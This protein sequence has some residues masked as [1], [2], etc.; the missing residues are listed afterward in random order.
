MAK[1]TPDYINWVLTLNATQAQ[2]EF[3]KLEKANKELQKRTNA[4][5]KAMAQLEAEGKK[6][7][8]EWDNLRKSVDQ[9][10]RAMA[11]NR[12]KM[13]EVAKR[14][15]LASMSVSQLRKR[16]KDLQREFNNTSKAAD[17]GRY[18]ELRR[19]IN[20]VQAALDKA[21][22]SA[23]GLQGGFFS[24]TKMKQTIIGFFIGVGLTIFA[25]I[26][27]AF[28]DAFNLVVDFEKANSRLASVLGTGRN[29][30]KDLTAAA[31]ELGATTS[32]T[33][34]EV[35]GLQIELAKLG[36]DKGQIIQMEAAVLKFAKAVDTDL[37]RA[38]AFAGAA[39]R[40]FGKDAADTESVLATFAVATTKT[41]LDFSKL[42]TSMSI[43]GPVAKAFGLSLEDTTAL[44]GQLANAGFDASSAATATRNIILNLCDANGDLAKALGA[45]VR[46]AAD[47]A[48]GLK[49]L[50]AEGIDLAKAL[51]LTDKRSVAAFSTFLASADSLGQLSDSITGVNRQFNSMA[52]TMGDNVAGAM[53]GLQ[54]A[55][56]E[57]V[58]K[59]SEGTNGPVK[60]LIN[61]LTSLVR[62]IGNVYE[63]LARFSGIVKIAAVALGL[64]KAA[65][66]AANAATKL[67]LATMRSGSA[68]LGAFRVASL[69][70]SAAMKLLSG[71]LAGASVALRAFRI[72]LVST[73]I[74]ALVAVLG[75]LC[76]ALMSF[77]SNAGKAKEKTDAWA[78][79]MAEAGKRYGEQ[80]GKLVSLIMVAE[81]ENL[82]LAKRQKAIAQLNKI[83]PD[84]NAKI[85]ETTGK[86]VAAK[87]K[88]DLYLDSLEKEMRYKA[89]EDKLKELLGISEAARDA[90]D[91]AEIK[92]AEAARF[93]KGLDGGKEYADK[94]KKEARKLKKEWDRAE[95]DYKAFKGRMEKA[96]E[97][98]IIT[99]PAADPA[100]DAV[101]NTGEAADKLLTRLKEIN[102]ELGQLRKTDPQSDVQLQG[103]KDRIN[104]LQEEKKQILDNKKLLSEPGV[105]QEE[106]VMQATAQADDDHQLRQLEIN[107][108]RP[109]IPDSEYTLEKAR[110]T[111]RYCE[112]LK[113]A[114]ETLRA[115][116]DVTH[117]DTLAAIAKRENEVA[118]ELVT[119]RETVDKAVVRQRAKLHDDIM[120]SYQAAADTEIAMINESAANRQISEEAAEIYTLARNRQLHQE[121][122]EELRDYLGQVRNSAEMSHDDREKEMERVVSLINK[123]QGEI[124]TDTGIFAKTINELMTD[125]TS[126]QGITDT[127]DLRRKRLES[128]YA[129]AIK[130]VGE[131]TDAAVALEAEMQRR[132]A[133]LNYQHL[134]QLWG[135]QE[136]TGMSWEDEY[137]RELAA[138]E[139]MHA[140]GLISTKEYENAKFDIGI[141]NA[142][143]YFD[144]YAG[145]SKSMFS[146]IQ[147]AEIA[148]SDAKYD[149]LIRQAQNNGEDTAALEEEKENKKLEIKKKYADVDFAIKVSEII[150]NTA[151]AAMAA[152]KIGPIAGPIAAAL[153]TATGM[154]Q[155]A[156]AKAERDKIKNLQPSRTASS[157]TVEKPAKATRQLTGYSDGG[158]TGDGDRYEV[159]GV[160]HRGEYVVPKPIMDNPRVIDAVGT[161]EAIRRN[162]LPVQAISA[163]PSPAGYADGGFTPAAPAPG[164][165][166]LATV[167]K[168]LQGAIRNIRAYIVYKD[169]ENAKETIDKARA[170]FT[171]K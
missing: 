58:L 113:A 97:D 30:I 74:G 1:L 69:L 71:N 124:L 135:I 171:R 120:K 18:N 141:K 101:T 122:L 65:A 151:V 138:L 88:L 41:A 48:T 4:T 153:V 52:D 99:P 136:Q 87:E 156:T 155:L 59:I 150:A 148:A 60:D 112:E 157:G 13:D 3:H 53:A 15:D 162:K 137:D 44:L 47:L 17:P 10:S 64:Y 111:I 139:N 132:L 164:Q 40:I 57:L 129:A 16:L 144:Y 31:R 83:I 85:D 96:M 130:I 169:L 160:V 12:A 80:K 14:F 105:Y 66:I 133:A 76:A 7:S 152:W 147:D 79:S 166:E 104:A 94:L 82:S 116:T 165:G 19:E 61:G 115:G 11:Q 123:A 9:N 8:A 168:E 167:L 89:N 161:I 72:A 142:K 2:E 107:K 63:W 42:E 98:G 103:I 149:T 119:A 140:Q 32:Y 131:G 84:Y 46:N 78:E 109:G 23:R 77:S 45:P 20:K 5:R 125:T 106:A 51:E 100:E 118:S 170:P 28:K 158:Y 35:T 55:A 154:A 102:A 95:L 27:G 134:E 121:Q 68:I 24:L 92:A 73:G 145:L 108:R 163:S 56:Q 114:L 54:S 34:A 62:I 159:A 50:N 49:K 38:S 36:F 70:A 43:V 143:K 37:A 127:F 117:T 93:L 128:T 86:Y 110:E 33:A 126:I 22:A 67:Y 25:L 90:Y 39:L 26:T 75:T 91:E 29:G 81:N 146:A 6:G 21:N